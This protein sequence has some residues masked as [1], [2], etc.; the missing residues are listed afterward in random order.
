MK[1]AR[2]CQHYLFSGCLT[3]IS[4]LPPLTQA[5]GAKRAWHYVQ[6]FPCLTRTQA[7]I[8]CGSKQ[9]A[10]IAEFNTLRALLRSKRPA[11]H[12]QLQMWQSP[13]S[14]S[15]PGTLTQP[16]RAALTFDDLK[17]S[18]FWTRDIGNPYIYV[19][20]TGRAELD[21]TELQQDHPYFCTSD[22]VVLPPQRGVDLRH[23]QEG[24]GDL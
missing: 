18:T 11:D 20:E 1:A 13:N 12:Q 24:D 7:M 4:L 19:F 21:L 2:V 23:T 10:S 9:L 8:E 16:T 3:L 6:D 15:I 5:A 17:N 22:P 14:T